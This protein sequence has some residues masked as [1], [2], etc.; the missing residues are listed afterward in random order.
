[1]F[2]R[3]VKSTLIKNY[4]MSLENVFQR[5]QLCILEL[6]NWSSYKKIMSLQNKKIRNLVILGLPFVN[7]KNL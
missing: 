6:L 3:W 1:M 4:H 2:D 5:L 7:L